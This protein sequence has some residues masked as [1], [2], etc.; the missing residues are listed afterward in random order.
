VFQVHLQ[1]PNWEEYGPWGWEK[2]NTHMS[3]TFFI[4]QLTHEVKFRYLFFST[5]PFDKKKCA[6]GHVS[7]LWWCLWKTGEVSLGENGWFYFLLV[8]NEKIWKPTLEKGYTRIER[9]TRFIL[10]G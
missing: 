3:K 4:G 9:T 8:Y 5:L 1:I 6:I 10:T 2:T 7:V